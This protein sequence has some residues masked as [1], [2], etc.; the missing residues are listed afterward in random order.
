MSTNHTKYG[1]FFSINNEIQSGAL[2]QNIQ[3]SLE[4]LIFQIGPRA[5]QTRDLLILR[6]QCKPL[7]QRA[8]VNK[9]DM[10]TNYFYKSQA[11][12]R[13]SYRIYYPHNPQSFKINSIKFHDTF[14]F[15]E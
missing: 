6:S 15:R 14:I 3:T 12:I 2:S 4:K 8:V 1:I 13:N 9:N 10:F 5:N 11:Y 7:G